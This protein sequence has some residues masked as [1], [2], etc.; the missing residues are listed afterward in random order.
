MRTRRSSSLVARR[1]LQRALAAVS[2]VAIGVVGSACATR[3]PMP[4][5]G[6]LEADAVRAEIGSPALAD[7][8]RD[9]NRRYW[10]IAFTDF[11]VLARMTE[12]QR[13]YLVP[14]TR[15]SWLE[16]A[17]ASCRT[18]WGV[19]ALTITRMSPEL[20]RSMATEQ[21]AQAAN[22]HG[23]A[24]V[25]E[26]FQAPIVR[27]VHDVARRVLMASSNESFDVVVDP[28]LG[29]QASVPVQFDSRTIYVGT[30][31]A[32]ATQSDDELACVLGHELAHVTEGHTTSGAWAEV[33]KLTL[34]TLVATA[35]LA[36]TAYANQGA[37]LTQSQIDGAVALGNLSSIVLAD[38]PLRLSGWGRD[39]ER[40]ADAMG[41][42][43]AKEAGYDP[44]ACARFMLG[45]A[46]TE[47][48]SGETPAPRWW[49]T[50]P[51]TPERVVAL[52][53]L[54]A[55]ARAGRLRPTED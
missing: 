46:R 36:A 29:L 26:E 11:T 28:A 48:A 20:L 35:A 22:F 10:D 52:R 7:V 5:V 41:L 31:L 34:S 53:K 39:Q 55:A 54:A 17:D 42:W 47:V 1:S 2:I 50:H 23:A 19:D 16:A 14:E 8:E 51:P 43:Y 3:L 18:Q 40:E 49:T 13:A 4:E 27:R 30:E 21:P 32:L 33:G 24:I 37:P 12:E 25:A 44:D 6:D 9:A 45:I 15:E 38:V